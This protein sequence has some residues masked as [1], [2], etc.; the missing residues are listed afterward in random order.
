M[1]DG[2]E[3]RSEQRPAS[4]ADVAA[5]MEKMF[6]IMGIDPHKQESLL[7][8]RAKFQFLETLMSKHSRRESWTERTT[9]GLLITFIF[10]VLVRALG[11]SS[12]LPPGH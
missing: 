2:K 8:G 6:F 5:M 9:I 7:A 3:H 1:W 4:I 12:T 11:I 10:A